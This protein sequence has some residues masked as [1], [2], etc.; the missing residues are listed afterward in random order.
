M[1]RQRH[2]PTKN[3]VGFMVGEVAYAVRIETVREIVNPLEVVELPRA[4][5]AV[6]GVASI[7]GEIVPVIDLRE[8]FALPPFAPSRKNKWL[9]V[10]VTP[11]SKLLTRDSAP[12]P[13][14]ARYV[15]LVVDSVTEVFGTGG[16]EI[17]PAPSLG[18]GDEV[19][20]IEGVAPYAGPGGLVFVLDVRLFGA[21]AD[22]VAG[23]IPKLPTS[24]LG[25]S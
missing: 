21:L 17:Q 14:A 22:A 13:S 11:R 6:R 12:P 23:G 19:R 3:L 18:V 10:D 16:A 5:K 24:P 9:V 20:G 8:R 1:P 15:A 2:D 7:R 25:V 4:P